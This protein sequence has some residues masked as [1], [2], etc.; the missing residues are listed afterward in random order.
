METTATRQGAPPPRV[1]HAPADSTTLRARMRRLIP[2]APPASAIA[3]GE[4]GITT[5]PID[6]ATATTVVR[7]VARVLRGEHPHHPA[8][9]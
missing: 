7:D 2:H 8:R 3:S 6:G 5:S 1:E 9:A 4:P